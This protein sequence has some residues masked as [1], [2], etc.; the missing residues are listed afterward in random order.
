MHIIWLIEW[1]IFYFRT[2]RNGMFQAFHVFQS[3]FQRDY[4]LST[5][6]RTRQKPSTFYSDADN[7]TSAVYLWKFK[8]ITDS[9]SRGC[10]T[11]LLCHLYWYFFI[12]N[13]CDYI[14]FAITFIFWMPVR[15]LNIGSFK[16]T[17]TLREI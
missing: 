5:D 16:Y 4:I 17:E 15:R 10:K 7:F 1:S 11:F 9:G 3:S 6:K 12:L 13:E 14:V 2:R 8:S